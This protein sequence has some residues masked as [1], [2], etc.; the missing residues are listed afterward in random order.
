MPMM[1]ECTSIILFVSPPRG[2]NARAARCD[3][4]NAATV[5]QPNLGRQGITGGGGQLP[6]PVVMQ[7]SVELTGMLLILGLASIFQGKGSRVRANR[8]WKGRHPCLM[9]FRMGDTGE[10]ALLT[11]TWTVGGR[12]KWHN[13]LEHM[14]SEAQPFQHS[15]K[16]LQSTRSNAFSALVESIRNGAR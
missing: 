6:P 12:V 5:G 7:L 14:G 8:S 4:G 13:Q 16:K 9:P 10:R 11:L 15:P 2:R 3:P 1:V